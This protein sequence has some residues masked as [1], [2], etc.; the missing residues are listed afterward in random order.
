M[1]TSCPSIC[2]H[3][4]QTIYVHDTCFQYKGYTMKL[5][6]ILSFRYSFPEFIYRSLE[7]YGQGCIR[8]GETGLLSDQFYRV[9]FYYGEGVLVVCLPLIILCFVTVNI[10]VELRKRKKRRRK[11]PCKL[12]ASHRLASLLFST[13]FL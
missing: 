5:I 11:A 1:A 13:L 12:L 7:S 3:V 4:Y 8:S 10:L 6:V 2:F 9:Y